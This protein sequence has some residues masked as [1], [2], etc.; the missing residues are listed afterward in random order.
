[1][2]EPLPASNI[3]HHFDLHFFRNIISFK[4]FCVIFCPSVLADSRIPVDD[5][6][7][8]NHGFRRPGY[9]ISAEPGIVYNMKKPTIYSYVPIIV[10]RETKQSFPDKMVTQYSG[11]HTLGQGGFADYVI[12]FGLQFK[13]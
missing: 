13:L 11:T 4:I 2:R 9:N 10:S 5:L 3:L 8:A 1:M 7:G 12:F 6:I